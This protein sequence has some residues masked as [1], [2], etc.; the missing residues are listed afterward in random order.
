MWKAPNQAAGRAANNGVSSVTDAAGR[1][2]ARLQLGRRGVLDARLPMP[3]PA[4]IYAQNGEMFFFVFCGVFLLFG[5]FG[6]RNSAFKRPLTRS[7]VK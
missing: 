1:T 3:A 7:S 5:Q 6:G 4:T 2:V